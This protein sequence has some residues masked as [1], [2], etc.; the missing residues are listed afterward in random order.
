MK[1]VKP[2]ASAAEGKGPDAAD[3]ATFERMRQGDAEAFSALFRTYYEP[4]YR[5]A[6]R[7]THDPQ[8]A[9]SLVQDVFVKVWEHR[10]SLQVRSNVKAYLYSAV[11]NHAL[12]VLK[13]EKRLV[14]GEALP[15]RPHTAR[16][17]EETLIDKETAAAVHRAVDKLPARCRQIYTMKRYDGLSYDEIASV[18]RISV[19]TVKT[20]M[21]RALSTLRKELS[22]L[23]S[24][25]ALWM[26]R[27]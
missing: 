23:I 3:L 4:L 22:F 16:T 19:N 15:E 5:F 10:E 7:F 14:H 9:E 18:L 24:V 2:H 11:R 20:Q 6:G 8:S 1:P 27:L 13:R 25:L 26:S 12:N 21:K 17:P